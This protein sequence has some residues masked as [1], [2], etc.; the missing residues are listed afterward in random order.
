RLLQPSRFYRYPRD[1]LADATLSIPEKRAILSAWVSDACAVDSLPTLR[2]APWSRTAVTF[3]EAMDALHTLDRD[4]ERL[5]GKSL[6][7]H[8]A[9]DTQAE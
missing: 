7:R 5:C 6:R 4:H 3:D 2:I 1:V 9:N 8:P